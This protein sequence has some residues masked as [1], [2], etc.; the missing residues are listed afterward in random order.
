MRAQLSLG[1]LCILASG[2]A[3]AVH[4]LQRVEV[5][6]VVLRKKIAFAV[7][8]PN[9]MDA[10]ER[11]PLVV[12]LHG[13]GDNENAFDQARIGQHLDTQLALG[14][15]PRVLVVVPNGEL[16]FWENWYDGSKNYRDWVITE[17]IP[18]VQ[19]EYHT[20]DCPAYCHVAGVSMG[21]H[22]T[23]RFAWFHPQ[24]FSSASA[25]SAPILSTKIILELSQRWFIRMFLPFEDIWGPVT[26]V[27]RIEHQDLYLQWTNPSDLK[28]VRLL[29]GAA[30]QDRDEI[31]KLNQKFHEHLTEHN[32]PHTY[33]E[34]DGKHNWKSWTPI[35]DEVLRF[36]VWGESRD[37]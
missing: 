28:G 11:L 14:H 19:A 16:G 31:I 4:R 30:K 33:V 22:G 18:T 7:W 5:Q 36:A 23:L 3:N 2:C 12:F 27:K 8:T 9:D 24:V 25:I 13:G 35:V 15:I 21:G 32:I 26:D 17:V 20:L 6:S 1:I 37:L 34:F 29:F 10:G